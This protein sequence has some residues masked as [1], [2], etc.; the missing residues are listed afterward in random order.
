MGVLN[1]KRCKGKLYFLFGK[2]NEKEDSAKGFSDFGGGVEPG[3]SI[4]ETAMREGG[5]ELTGFLGDGAH[6]QQYIKSHGGVFPIVVGEYHVHLFFIEYD[7]KLPMYYNL[8][9]RF[10]WDRMDKHILHRSKLFEKIEIQWFSLKDMKQRRSEFRPFYREIV[11]QFILKRGD[12]MTFLRSKAR[13]TRRVRTK[14]TM[15]RRHNYSSSIL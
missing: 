9:H 14:K 5:E 15:S 3:E 7:P 12:I 1:E 6:I 11:D 2:E 8:N 10:L 13:K 4:Y